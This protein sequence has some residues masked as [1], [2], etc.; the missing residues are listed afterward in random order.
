MATPFKE[1]KINHG[2]IDVFMPEEILY[3]S[4]ICAALQKMCRKRMA[5]CV[6]ARRFGNV[7]FSKRFLNGPGQNIFA[8]MVPPSLPTTR[9]DREI[10]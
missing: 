8:K 10:F 9:I 5:E 3:S 2:R 1:V 4:D 6:R 7:G